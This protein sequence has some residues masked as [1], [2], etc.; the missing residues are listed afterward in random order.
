MVIELNNWTIKLKLPYYKKVL[1]RQIGKG[2]NYFQN[3]CHP[4]TNPLQAFFSSENGKF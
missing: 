4:L 3:L 2:T 1:K